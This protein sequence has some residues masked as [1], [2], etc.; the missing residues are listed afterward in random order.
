MPQHTQTGEISALLKA[1]ADPIRMDVVQTLAG[2]ERCVCELTETLGLAQSRLSFH[3]KVMRQ[4]G[5]ITA[6][7][8]GRW[9]YYKLVPQA[10]EQLQEWLNSL[11][12]LSQE[13]AQGCS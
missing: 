7:E 3:L 9:V 11:K 4:S 1:L 12:R 2:G 5:L 6:R 8:E 10:F 13:R